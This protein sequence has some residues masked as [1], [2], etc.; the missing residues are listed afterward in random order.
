MKGIIMAKGVVKK[1]QY[2]G[3]TEDTTIL[4]KE[5]H[6]FKRRIRE[7]IEIQKHLGNVNRDNGIELSENWLPLIH[8]NNNI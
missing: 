6:L 5:N 2:V 4:A 3:L 1:M 7:A 8:K